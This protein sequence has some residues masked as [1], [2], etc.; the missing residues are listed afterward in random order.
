MATATCSALLAAALLCNAPADP[1]QI[2]LHGAP[3][4]GTV[5]VYR[6]ATPANLN[7]GAPGAEQDPDPGQSRAGGRPILRN[8]LIGLSIGCVAGATMSV[9]GNDDAHVFNC[10][11]VAGV[12]A[13]VAAIPFL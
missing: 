7:A 11:W 3:I 13:A 1:V 5:E 2:T 4:S 9:R 8:V 10:L 12:G 6:L